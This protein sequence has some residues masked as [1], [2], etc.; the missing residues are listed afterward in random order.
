[1]Q[2]VQHAALDKN[3][4]QEWALGSAH[5]MIF[6]KLPLHARTCQA[7]PWNY[8]KIDIEKQ[9]EWSIGYFQA[10]MIEGS[11]CPTLLPCPPSEK[12]VCRTS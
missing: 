8:G 5:V 10:N 6:I 12:A 9:A 2:I 11:P 1:M 4:Q 3:S 7:T